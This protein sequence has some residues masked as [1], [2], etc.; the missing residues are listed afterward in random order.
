[1]AAYLLPKDTAKRV[2]DSLPVPKS[3]KK[4]PS[5]TLG[6]TSSNRIPS[7]LISKLRA[8]TQLP[9]LKLFLE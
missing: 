8:D 2:S 3:L 5:E 7:G 4:K 9:T 6:T 1:M